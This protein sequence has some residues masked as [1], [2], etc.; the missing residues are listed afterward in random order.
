MQ[1]DE[2]AKIKSL[3]S[4]ASTLLWITFQHQAIDQSPTEGLVSGL[5]RTLATES[6]DYRLSSISL[7]LETG[8]DTVAA[9][10]VKVATTLLEPQIDP[11][12]EYCEIDG[13]LCTPRV[14]DDAELTVQALPTEDTVVYVTKP[15]SELDS[16]KLTIGAAGVLN[17]LH[18]EQT[19]IRINELASDDVIIQVK[20]VGLNMRDI[21]VAL[22]QVH[23]ETFGSEIAGVVVSTGSSHDAGFQI[24]D[25]VFGV[26]RDGVAQL[27]R[28]KVS[29]LQRVP[30]KMS[31]CEAAAYPVAFCT[32][33]YSLK[34]C[35]SMKSGDSILVHDA[36]SVLG[37]AIIK[38]A[39]FHG[40]TKIFA[41]V[42]TAD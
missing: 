37:Q 3:L 26:T 20:A 8:L 21:L 19:S 1:K 10:I 33:Y 2:L 5:V 29:Q 34:Q 27:A 6:E 42:S 15:W 11:E 16:P 24:G 17:T 18:Y 40:Y 4:K 39:A 23:D 32:A 14:V 12:D 28:C 13:R 9:N 38:I 41:T 36:A 7:D 30:D 25:R 31:F 22:G 35:Y